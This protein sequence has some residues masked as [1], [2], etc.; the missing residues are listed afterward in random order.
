VLS[1]TNN[2]CKDKH[3]REAQKM[4]CFM[5]T[6]L[7]D[8]NYRKHQSNSPSTY[9]S[10]KISEVFLLCSGVNRLQFQQHC[11]QSDWSFQPYKVIPMYLVLRNSY[12]PW[13]G[14]SIKLGMKICQSALSFFCFIFLRNNY[15]LLLNCWNFR[16]LYS[17]RHLDALL[18]FSNLVVIHFKD[19][20]N[21]HSITDTVGNRMPT[22]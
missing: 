11:D 6:L 12:R 9:A 18:T 1:W 2:E 8:L 16:T 15:N 22:K 13:N 3:S 14:F 4:V 21:C 7:R 20:I 17:R 5:K 10:L 19:K